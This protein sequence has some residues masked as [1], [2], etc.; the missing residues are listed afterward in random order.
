MKK[1]VAAAL[2]VA[3]VSACAS[4]SENITAAYVSP[5]LYQNLSCNQ[6]REEASTISSRAVAASGAQDKKAGNDAAV[7][8]VGLIVFWP[9]L[10]FTSGDGAQAAEVARL[11][12]EMDAIETASRRNNCG[13][14]FNKAPPKPAPAPSSSPHA[15]AKR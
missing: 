1:L 11:K 6:L 9:A 15:P 5:T 13:I 3:S 4:R 12:G 14:V 8:A 10:L 2:M 7:M